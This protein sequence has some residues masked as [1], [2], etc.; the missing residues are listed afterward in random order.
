VRQFHIIPL[1]ELARKLDRKRQQLRVPGNALISL[2]ALHDE[3]DR[4]ISRIG[5]ATLAFDRL[6]ILS[7]NFPLITPA[8]QLRLASVLIDAR[9]ISLV[10]ATPNRI[11][12]SQ[13]DLKSALRHTT[14]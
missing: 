13:T 14:R 2:G 5:W 6:A 9:Q 1:S 3:I 7:T 4:A 8:P 11:R 12:F 10:D